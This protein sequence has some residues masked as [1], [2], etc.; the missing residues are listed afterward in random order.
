MRNELRKQ[1]QRKSLMRK[2][3]RMKD[4]AVAEEAEAV[5]VEVVVVTMVVTRMIGHALWVADQDQLKQSTFTANVQNSKPMT[6]T[7]HT[8]QHLQD[9]NQR[10]QNKSRP[11]WSSM[12]T[13][14]QLYENHDTNN[15]ILCSVVF[16]QNMLGDSYLLKRFERVDV[17]EKSCAVDC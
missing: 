12:R 16:P 8:M 2:S 9:L 11:T 4:P 3:Q 15:E 6:T 13:T 1:K 14:I 10:R 17:I 5:V 7:M